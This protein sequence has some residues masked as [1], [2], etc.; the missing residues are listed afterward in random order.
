MSALRDIQIIPWIFKYNTRIFFE[1]GTGLGS[2]LMRMIQPEYG[3]ELLISCDIDK[4]LAE[5]SQRTFSFDTRVL[6][7]NDEGPNVLRNI[8]PK[9]PL[10][11][12]IFFWLDSHFANSDYNLGHKPLVPHSEGDADIRLPALHEFKI[13][14]ELR[15]DKGAKDF[16]LLD[17]AMLY[18]EK[19][20]YEDCVARLG[21]NAVPSEY[22][23]ILDKT[24]ELFKETHTA[25]VITIAQGFLALHPK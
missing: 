14:K 5:H 11:K 9:I 25:Q 6:I 17:D 20:R 8:L 2:G 23:K 13:I 24:V 1:T 19:D 7:I 18:D 21:E 22:R 10:N 4:E 3:Q 16:M 15:I 12:P